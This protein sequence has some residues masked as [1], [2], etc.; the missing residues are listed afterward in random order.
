MN[1]ETMQRQLEVFRVYGEEGI[2]KIPYDEKVLY[3][4][5]ILRYYKALEN[6]MDITF[7]MFE[8]AYK[9]GFFSREG[10]MKF[11]FTKFVTNDGIERFVSAFFN[12]EDL[13]LVGRELF[14]ETIEY[15][16]K[17]NSETV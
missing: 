16:E 13:E 14:I 4:V 12:G 9:M 6:T 15:V 17:Q 3:Q 5:L 10:I 7:D 1:K 8:D 11:I 2:T